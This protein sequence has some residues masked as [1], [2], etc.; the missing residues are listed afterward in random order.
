MKE[1]KTLNNKTAIML[2]KIDSKEIAYL[3]GFICADG[4]IS[5]NNNVELGVKLEDREIVDFLAGIL[6]AK[7]I[8]DLTLNRKAKRFP[9]ARFSRSIKDI[10]KFVK[11]R[12][13]NDRI[14]PIIPKELN[15]YLILGFFDGD[16]CITWGRRKDRN[17]IWQKISFTSS[18]K[19]LTHVQQILYKLN[20]TSIIH[21][22]KGEN[23]FVL[24]IAALDDVMKFGNWLYQDEDFIILKRK[25]N[26]FNALRL[27]LDKFG[28]TTSNNGTIPSQA[29]RHRIEGLETSGGKMGSLNN[30][31][32]I[33]ASKEVRYSPHR[34]H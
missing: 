12:L 20:I 8:T 7:V 27:E 34:G 29:I 31:N 26:R 10:L 13:K 1:I 3:V 6:N 33:Q 11:S 17:R 23:T 9:R 2:E 25:F 32:N 30:H 14:L 22:K 28:G 19:M 4:A 21:P 16:G 18:Y 24:E 15:R 5:S